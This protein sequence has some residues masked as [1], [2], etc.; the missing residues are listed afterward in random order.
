MCSRA[1]SICPIHVFN[2]CRQL[3]DFFS[4]PLPA[5]TLPPLSLLSHLYLVGHSENSILPLPSQ[6]STIVGLQMEGYQ[7][8]LPILLCFFLSYFITESNGQWSTAMLSVFFLLQC[9]TFHCSF[10]QLCSFNIIDN[11]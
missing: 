4:F 3:L 6:T 1:N 2:Y 11:T 7:R 9:Y 8:H 10:S 5:F